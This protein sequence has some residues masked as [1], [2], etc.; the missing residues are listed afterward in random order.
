MEVYGRL[1]S[2]GAAT[3]ADTRG[4]APQTPG[5]DARPVRP[6]P[7]PLGR[8]HGRLARRRRRPRQAGRQR[9]RSSASR[10]VWCAA[11]RR[12]GRRRAPGCGTGWRR[13]SSCS[14]RSSRRSTPS[15]SSDWTPVADGTQDAMIRQQV[16]LLQSWAEAGGT[17][18]GYIF[19]HEPHDNADI[20]RRGRQVRADR[21]TPSTPAPA[22]RPSSSTA[23]SGS[24]PSSTS[25]APTG[26]SSSTP[27]RCRGRR[28][29]HRA[30]ACSGRAIR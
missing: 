24:G 7:P 26:S 29:R 9:G 23:T 10:S 13:A 3:G 17:Q 2:A 28:R 5:D 25:S 16:Q 27:Q 30:A 14:G 8:R 12:R 15:A 19:H 20:L 11:T 1:S 18:A 22:P 4:A 21:A 6:G